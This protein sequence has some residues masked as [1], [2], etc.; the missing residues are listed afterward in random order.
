M[1]T[2]LAFAWRT[3]IWSQKHK[4]QRQRGSVSSSP[5]WTSRDLFS[6]KTSGTPIA[7]CHSSAARIILG[8][9]LPPGL[10]APPP[11]ASSRA[12]LGFPAPSGV[13]LPTKSSLT[14]LTHEDASSFRFLKHLPNSAIHSFGL[15]CLLRYKIVHGHSTGDTHHPPAHT[16]KCTTHQ[17]QW[18]YRVAHKISRDDPSCF[19]ET[20]CL[21]AGNPPLSSP[22]GNCHTSLWVYDLG[23]FRLLM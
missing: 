21:S 15:L 10:L 13:I 2:S 9:L 20:L 14:Q 16:L 3:A 8:V 7:P 1:L 5:T 23:Y 17:S 19:T 4:W 12:L 22:P 18:Q 6:A 11:P